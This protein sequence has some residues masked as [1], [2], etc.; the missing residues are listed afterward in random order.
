MLFFPRAATNINYQ[1]KAQP[2]TQARAFG[3]VSFNAM[4]AVDDPSAKSLVRQQGSDGFR[5]DSTAM[6]Q[7]FNISL[8]IYINIF[9]IQYSLTVFQYLL[10]S[11]LA[12]VYPGNS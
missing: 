3:D 11:L 12:T 9:N 8:C 4:L 5:I 7:V 6:F 2:E 1:D 10:Q